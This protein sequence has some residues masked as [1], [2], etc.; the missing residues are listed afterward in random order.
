[1]RQ[2]RNGNTKVIDYLGYE[3][4]IRKGVRNDSDESYSVIV[5]EPAGGGCCFIK[6]RYSNLRTPEQEEKAIDKAKKFIEFC[7]QENPQENKS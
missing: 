3:I 6:K 1:M 2:N 4:Q 5:V 7:S